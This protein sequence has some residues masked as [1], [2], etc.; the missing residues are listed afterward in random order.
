MHSRGAAVEN[1]RGAE[2]YSKKTRDG[3]EFLVVCALPAPEQASGLKPVI[4]TLTACQGQ[5]PNWQ[6]NERRAHQT[7]IFASNP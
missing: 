6:I 4:S 5:P 3:C 1:L 7:E 2:E